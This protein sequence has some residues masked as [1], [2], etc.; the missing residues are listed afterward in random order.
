MDASLSTLL[1]M[2][3]LEMQIRMIEGLQGKEDRYYF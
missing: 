1:L 3:I 2:Q